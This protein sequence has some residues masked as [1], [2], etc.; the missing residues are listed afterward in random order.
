[1]YYCVNTVWVAGARGMSRG[2]GRRPGK[3]SAAGDS[4]SVDASPEQSA[5]CRAENGTGRA[6]AVRVDRSADKRPAGSAD[7][8]SRCPIR[9][10]AAVAAFGVPPDFAV[11]AIRHCRRRNDGHDH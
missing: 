6:L 8:Q 4:A 7:D 3:K 1:V 5:C 10:L 11:V 9:P 2:D